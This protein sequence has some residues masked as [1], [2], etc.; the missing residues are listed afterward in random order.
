MGCRSDS[1]LFRSQLRLT[2][3]FCQSGE[4]SLQTL[5]TKPFNHISFLGYYRTHPVQAARSKRPNYIGLKWAKDC[6]S[7]SWS[8]TKLRSSLANQQ[9]CSW[10]VREPVISVTGFNPYNPWEDSAKYF[11]LHKAIL[12]CWLRIEISGTAPTGLHGLCTEPLMPSVHSRNVDTES[13]WLLPPRKCIIHLCCQ[14]PK[15]QQ[16]FRPHAHLSKSQQCPDDPEYGSICEWQSVDFPYGSRDQI[17][18][19]QLEPDW[20]CTPVTLLSSRLTTIVQSRWLKL[21]FVCVK[22][23]L[24]LCAFHSC[25]WTQNTFPH[26]S[27]WW[28]STF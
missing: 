21:Q 2:E 11:Q 3:E 4:I 13:A 15:S 28:R 16:I 9:G 10:T 27:S 5:K 22:F 17:W 14:W 7:L 6:S 26:F 1:G 18:I 8:P 25:C 12:T 20:S 19:K 24:R 23:W